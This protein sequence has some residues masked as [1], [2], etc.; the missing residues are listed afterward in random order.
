MSIRQYVHVSAFEPVDIDAMSFALDGVC[1]SLGLSDEAT[2]AKQVIAERI[3]ELARRG[4]RDPI[5]L[6]DRVLKE[7]NGS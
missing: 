1:E 7:A 2:G 6:R 3:L 4:E 5:S